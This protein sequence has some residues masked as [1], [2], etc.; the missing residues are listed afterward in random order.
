[1][2]LYCLFDRFS[3]S[4]KLVAWI[5]A[6]SICISLNAYCAYNYRTDIYSE[7]NKVYN[8]PNEKFKKL[9]TYYDRL[10]IHTIIYFLYYLNPDINQ[11]IRS[12]DEKIKAA[13]EENDEKIDDGKRQLNF[14]VIVSIKDCK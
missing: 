6:F 4:E 14:N 2:V 9:N 8:I 13:I 10:K 5:F 12:I 3:F 11:K 1:M 7:I